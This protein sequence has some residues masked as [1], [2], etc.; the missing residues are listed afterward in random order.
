MSNRP[1]EISS[2]SSRMLRAWKARWKPGGMA[3]AGS[4]A[5]RNCSQAP[6]LS[7]RAVNITIMRPLLRRL[8]RSDPAEVTI[9]LRSSPPGPPTLL[10]AGALA[11]LAETHLVEE[12]EQSAAQSEGDQRDGQHL[13]EEAPD[14]RRGQRARDDQ[15]G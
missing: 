11:V 7:R 2:S 13:A 3:S 6:G 10:F 12:K 1:N 9:Y 14:Q 5:R 8:A 15:R 4:Q